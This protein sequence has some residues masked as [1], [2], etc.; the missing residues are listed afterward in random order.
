MSRFL[1]DNVSGAHPEIVQALLEANEQNS[2][3]YGDDPYSDALDQIF[4]EFFGT[5]VSVIPCLSGTAA[6]ALAISLVAGATQSVYVHQDSHIYQDEC[7]APEFYSCARLI[8][9]TD[10]DSIG[11]AKLTQE[12]FKAIE[13]RKGDR[14]SVQAAAISI[15]QINELGEL[16]QPDEIR[17]LADYAHGQ[18]LKL[19]MDGARFANA[20][21]A[22]DCHPAD[23]SWRSGVDILSFGATKNGCFGA[24]AVVL[25]NPQ[26]KQEAKYRAKRAGQLVSKMRFVSAQLLAYIKN[27]LWIRNARVANLAAEKLAKQLSQFTDIK[28]ETPKANMLYVTLPA[29]MTTVLNKAELSGYFEEVENN[30]YSMRLCTSWDTRDEDIEVFIKTLQAAVLDNN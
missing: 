12:M 3:P 26:Q 10:V 30:L 18:G 19:H 21:A 23:I 13:G 20:V 1:S 8:P 4:S 14:H 6:N 25:F 17:A 22:L 28:A 2:A 15:A 9:F 24:E 29:F 27:D 11:S 16:Y 5:P 7:N